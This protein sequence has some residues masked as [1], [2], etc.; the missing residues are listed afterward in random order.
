M[1]LAVFLA[2]NVIAVSCSRAPQTL[3]VAQLTSQPEKYNGKQVTV[4][5][6]YLGG[7]EIVALSN[8]LVPSTFRQGNV[9]PKEPLIWVTGSLGSAV[10]NKLYVQNNTRP[11]TPNG[12]AKYGLPALL[13]TGANTAKW[14]HT[15]TSSL[16]PAPSSPMDS[17]RQL[18]ASAT[19][20]YSRSFQNLLGVA[21]A[22]C[23]CHPFGLVWGFEFLILDLN[24]IPVSSRPDLR[25]L[26]TFSGLPASA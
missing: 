13:N 5:G 15:N 20:R 21:Q 1:L 26:S 9:S 23:L 14:T 2:V 18:T 10:L 25:I 7:F 17:A 11:A 6:F 16:S 3:S 4:E 19:S 8:E 12:M 24:Q 22:R